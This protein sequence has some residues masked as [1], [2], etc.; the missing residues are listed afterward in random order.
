MGPMSDVTKM[1]W[2]C[3]ADF[4][5]ATC[6]CH[7][8][9]PLLWQISARSQNQA[10]SK[11]VCSQHTKHGTAEPF[12]FRHMGLMSDVTMLMRLCV[13]DFGHAMCSCHCR[14]QKFGRFQPEPS[15]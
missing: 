3:V 2:L 14:R 1:K 11:I 12:H 6:S 15:Q 8:R 13:A 9:W 10:N 7:C 4:G 5:Y